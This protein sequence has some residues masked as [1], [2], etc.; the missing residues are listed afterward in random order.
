MR[1]QRLS[2]RLVVV[3]HSD[4][5]PDAPAA[6]ISSRRLPISDAANIPETGGRS[7]RINWCRPNGPH[8]ADRQRVRA[9]NMRLC[10]LSR[11]ALPDVRITVRH[12][13]DS[14]R[15]LDRSL[16]SGRIVSPVRAP[17]IFPSAADHRAATCRSHRWAGDVPAQISAPATRFC[18]PRKF[19][20]TPRLRLIDPRHAEPSSD[21]TDSA[22]WFCIP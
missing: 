22:V 5:S 15:V 16:A 11:I 6:P 18:R 8:R 17:T 1:R 12:A 21:L 14:L 3:H 4:R 19:R 2:S 7:S 20:C 9:R 10:A 13:A